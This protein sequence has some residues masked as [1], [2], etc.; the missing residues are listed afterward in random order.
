ML[1][2]SHKKPPKPT[3]KSK[4]VPAGAPWNPLK[5]QPVDAATTFFFNPAVARTQAPGNGGFLMGNNPAGDVPW[6]PTSKVAVVPGR[7]HLGV[8]STN[9]RYGYLWMPST[10]ILSPTAFTIEFWVKS[11][12]PFSSVTG[13]PMSIS[14]VGFSFGNGYLTRVVCKQRALSADP[15]NADYACSLPSRQRLGKLC[16]DLLASPTRVVCQRKARREQERSAGT[17]RCGP[18]TTAAAA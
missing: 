7:F 10:G 17:R 5:P 11:N 9:Y 8:R 16:A 18:T 1:G 14:G 4:P 12:L 3:H 15:G 2:K 6:Q 13:V